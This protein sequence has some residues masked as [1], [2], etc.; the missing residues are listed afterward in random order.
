MSQLPKDF[1]REKWT[2]E[3]QK[4]DAKRAHDKHLDFFKNLN[5]ASIKSGELAL[6]TIL[7][8]NGGAAAATLAFIGG[9][10][11]QGKISTAQ[12]GSF[13]GGLIFFAYGVVASALGIGATYFVHFFTGGAEAS[14][15]LTWEHPY[16]ND[17]PSTKRWMWARHF[18]HFLAAVLALSAILLFVFGMLD[19]RH[20]ITNLK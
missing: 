18:F 3:I 14:K 15:T 2:Y 10:A 4:E 12:L 8:V 17:T 19:I 20:A 9:L 11:G 5:E 1:D 16:I 13:T 6:R 7:I